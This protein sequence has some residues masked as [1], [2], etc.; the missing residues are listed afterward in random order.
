MCN[1]LMMM[2]CEKLNKAELVKY[3]DLNDNYFDRKISLRRSNRIFY[4]PENHQLI[5]PSDFY[6]PPIND[7]PPQNDI[8]LLKS[9]KQLINHTRR[10]LDPK[11]N[12]SRLDENYDYESNYDQNLYQKRFEGNNFNLKKKKKNKKCK[13]ECEKDLIIHVPKYKYR[14]IPLGK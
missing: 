9:L 4:P 12:W 14:D 11:E 13:C 5:Y 6:V 3:G 2:F 7:S 10:K 1:F 8:H